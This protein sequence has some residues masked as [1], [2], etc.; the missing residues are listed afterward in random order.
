MVKDLPELLHL[1]IIMD[2]EVLEVLVEQLELKGLTG[3]LVASKPLEA[4]MGEITAV[5]VAV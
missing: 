1:G 5:A 2:Q 4:P 3:I